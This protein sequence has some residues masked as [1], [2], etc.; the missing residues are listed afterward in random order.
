MVRS[1]VENK[2][3][4]R[5][6]RFEFD[7]IVVGSGIA[8]LSFILAL[9]EKHPD[10]KI[11]LVTKQAMVES[12]SQYAQGGIAAVTTSQDDDAQHIADTLAAGDGLCNVKTVKSIINSSCHAISHLQKYG[13]DFNCNDDVAS[14]NHEGGHSQRRIL[15]VGD[16]TG[17]HIIKKLTA[18]VRELKQVTIFE[19]HTVV[20][21]I[22]QRPQHMPGEFAE[23]VGA[24]VLDEKLG[25]IHTFIAKQTVLATGGV[26]K[27]YRYTS[28]SDIAT[29]DGIAMAYRAGARVDNME[30]YQFHPTL[31]YHPEKNN[32][33]I[34]EAVR[35]EGGILRL[36]DTGERF[37][38]R[39][40][41][42]QLELATRD[43]VARAIFTEIER[44]DF[45][46]VHL[47][48]THQSKSFLQQRFPAIFSTLNNLG[49]DMSQDMIPVVPAAHYLCGGVL[50]NI[51]G[52]TD[53]RRLLA[54][55]EM[56]FTGFHGANR[57]AS[58][59]LLESVVMA[60]NAAE[61][62]EKLLLQPFSLQYDIKDWDSQCVRD[63]RRASQINAHWRSLR[64]EM[65][66]YAGIVRTAAG[67][68]DLLTLIR[69]RKEMVEEYYWKHVVTRD[70]I[71]LRN[72]ILVAELIVQAALENGESRGCH[73]REDE[74]THVIASQAMQS[75]IEV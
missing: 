50:T 44:S 6:E 47:D 34:S 60:L 35:G 25:L 45:N 49:I 10:V 5:G 62:S 41:P 55:G 3:S 12:N 1:S 72:I 17:W 75:S 40:A 22:T 8:G 26:G 43:V 32:F 63:Y 39:Y 37:M 74:V 7:M 73:F 14:L 21:L 19:F 20:N 61:V 52:Q 57:L 13:V 71:E 48:I 70:F 51:A 28:N 65:M 2:L 58:N 23:V 27:T 59:S 38:Q 69:L 4:Q 46:Y 11:A 68:K 36:P 54:I 66:S 53:L 67:L 56:A 15:H 16:E 33:L 64:G 31:L 42:E 24:Y 9:A 29:G 18:A 30:Y